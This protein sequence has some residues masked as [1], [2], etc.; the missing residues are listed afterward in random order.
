[1][2]IYLLVNVCHPL[3][4]CH[5][6]GASK[7]VRVIEI[8]EPA[9]FWCSSALMCLGRLGEWRFSGCL[10]YCVC[11]SLFRMRACCCCTAAD[12]RLIALV[13]C[14]ATLHAARARTT[15]QFSRVIFCGCVL[16]PCLLPDE[17]LS[18]MDIFEKYI[19]KLQNAIFVSQKKCARGKWSRQ[20]FDL[21]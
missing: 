8:S 21:T 18:F 16:V 14:T 17:I 11:S 6:R 3:G 5:Q 12:A 10:T 20:F 4:R 13:A 1:M 2:G 9:A 19:S 7:S 15:I